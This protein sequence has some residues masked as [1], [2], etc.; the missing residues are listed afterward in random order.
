MR[1]L[2]DAKADKDK[3]LQNNATSMFI[4][5]Q[6][7]HLEVVRLLLEAKADKNK[8]ANSGESLMTP[9]VQ[10]TLRGHTEIVRLINSDRAAAHQRLDS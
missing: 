4:A 9:L 6:N 5:A 2:L 8:A 10:A 1:L 7:G 3:A